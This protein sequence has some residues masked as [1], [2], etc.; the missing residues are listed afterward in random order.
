M[1]LYQLFLIVMGY[2]VDVDGKK[3]QNRKRRF[4]DFKL[5]KDPRKPHD[6]QHNKDCLDKA[7]YLAGLSK[8]RLYLFFGF[9]S[10][11]SF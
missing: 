11:D 10:F 1:E 2:F 4:L 5:I 6:K 7:S 8:P 3:K 9:Q